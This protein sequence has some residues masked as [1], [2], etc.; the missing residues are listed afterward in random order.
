MLV[1]PRWY[2][3]SEDVQLGVFIQRQTQL[4]QHDFSITVLYA[5]PRL[6]QKELYRLEEKDH[7][8]VREIRIYYKQNTGPFKKLVNAF[9]YRN[10]TKKALKALDFLPSFCHVHVPYRPLFIANY[11]KRKKQ[12]PFVVTEHWSGHLLGEFDTKNSLD[13]LLYKRFLRKATKI[14]TVSKALQDAFKKNTGHDSV[15]IP[16]YIEKSTQNVL[17]QTDKGIHVL[18]ISDLDN[19]TKNITGLIRAFAKA[20]EIN[21]EMHLSI[22]G[23]GPDKELIQSLISELNVN[24]QVA[25]VGRQ[26]HQEVLKALR[27]CDFY[28]NHSA[29]ETFSMSSAEALMAGKPVVAT[30]SGGPE[31]FL[32]EQNSRLVTQSTSEVNTDFVD[33]LVWMAENFKTFSPEKL[34]AAVEHK[35]GYQA[36][37][38]K[39][40]EFYANINEN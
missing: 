3:N 34:S 17:Q 8:E 18:S 38:E 23:D 19:T 24:K 12:I 5:Q 2:P 25:L 9:R 36:V 29:V 20:L 35:F 6:H 39:W 13:K 21:D 27:H 40:L 22:I 14:S 30:R 16:N 31:E 32:N 15:I 11:L 1:L 28:V 33:A 37:R 7:N 4:M 26:P 10:S